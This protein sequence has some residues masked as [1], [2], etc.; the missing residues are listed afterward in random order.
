MI[1][2][3]LQQNVSVVRCDSWSW[4]SAPTYLSWTSAATPYTLEHLAAYTETA[5]RRGL[6]FSALSTNDHMVF[7]VPW[8]DGPTA[9][10]AMIGR[11]VSWSNTWRVVAR[12]SGSSLVGS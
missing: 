6:S 9:F 7:S 2:R 12:V 10:V 4:T 11:K 5:A 1:T 8:L 3:S